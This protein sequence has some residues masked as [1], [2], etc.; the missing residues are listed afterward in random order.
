MN[1]QNT[2]RRRVC[3]SWYHQ[4][5][6]RILLVVVGVDMMILGATFAVGIDIVSFVNSF[7]TWLR[8]VFGIAY[9]S[10]AL[11]IIHY[12]LSYQQM[13]RD[14]HFVCHHCGHVNDLK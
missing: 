9:I 4:T 14:A 1:L 2:K 13:K 11:F 12:A 10:V 6:F 5:W 8:V 7:D 3:N